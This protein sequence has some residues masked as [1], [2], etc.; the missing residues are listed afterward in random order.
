MP[1]E[2]EVL[3]VILEFHSGTV[4]AK[5]EASQKVLLSDVTFSLQA[6]E[7]L[8]LIGETGSGKTMTAMALMGL[9]PPNVTAADAH[10]VFCGKPLSGDRRQL[11][12]VDMVYIPQNGLEFL[13][14][15]KKVRYHL[16]D[17]LQKLGIP[18]KQWES[19]ALQTLSA[20]GFAQP[21]AVIGKYPFQLSGG[22]AQRVTIAI[23]ACSRAKLVIADEPTNGLDS[24]AKVR[25]MDML[26]TL[27]PDAAKLMITHDISLA[28]LC[29]KTL[30]LC[31]GKRMEAGMSAELF[32]H[33]RHPYTAALVGALVKNGM[34][35]TPVLRSGAHTCPFYARCARA[36][37][38]CGYCHRQEDGREWW[39]SQV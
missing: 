29:D 13:N 34:A 24:A 1:K 37:D 15:S 4:T 33:P 5:L 25:F 10:G 19:T 17:S 16:Y 12:G 3:S 14:P 27:F 28:A 38:S 18:R 7:S 22:M 30:V 6:G 31:G 9:L 39:C 8:A 20:V 36:E 21:E 11:L 32:A 26:K 2:G 23:S 35:E